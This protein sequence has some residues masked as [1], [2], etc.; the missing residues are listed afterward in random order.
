MCMEHVATDEAMC[1]IRLFYEYFRID[2]KLIC[3]INKSDYCARSRCW[4]IRQQ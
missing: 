3:Q 2:D 1:I 4:N